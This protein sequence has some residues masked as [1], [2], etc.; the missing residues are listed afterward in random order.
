MQIMWDTNQ[1]IEKK[2]SD[3]LQP[4]VPSSS[5]TSELSTH[6]LHLTFNMQ[7]YILAT[8]QAENFRC[9]PAHLEMHYNLC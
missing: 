5:L 1:K 4:T 9:H 6:I 3:L 7:A 8:I 2:K